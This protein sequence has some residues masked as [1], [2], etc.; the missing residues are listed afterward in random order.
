MGQEESPE[1]QRSQ[2]EQ[3]A[4][5]G[6]IRRKERN[7]DPCNELGRIGKVRK[8]LLNIGE[9]RPKQAVGCQSIKKRKSLQL[10]TEEVVKYC[11]A[12]K[13]K[14]YCEFLK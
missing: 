11:Q 8:L 1:R 14:I 7:Q 10:G 4:K 2:W 6:G 12:E 3:R 5:D 9:E 13:S